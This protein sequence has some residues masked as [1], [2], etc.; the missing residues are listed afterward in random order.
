MMLATMTERQLIEIHA[1]VGGNRIDTFRWQLMVENSPSKQ[2]SGQRADDALQRLTQSCS[3]STLNPFL[4]FPLFVQEEFFRLWNATN[5]NLARVVTGL[6]SSVAFKLMAGSED[7][8][9]KEAIMMNNSSHIL[10]QT[11][12]LYIVRHKMFILANQS[13]KV[14]RSSYFVIGK[15]LIS[16]SSVRCSSI[17]RLNKKAQQKVAHVKHYKRLAFGGL[18]R[19]QGA[20]HHGVA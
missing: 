12:K 19:S 9:K 14:Q 2:G 4:I 13:V 8:P 17:G 5:V 10:N 18:M 6:V 11:T 7:E 20:L 3:S 1:S 15:G 16:R